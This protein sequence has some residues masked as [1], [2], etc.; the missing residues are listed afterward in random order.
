MSLADELAMAGEDSESGYQDETSEMASSASE[1]DESDLESRNET[2]LSA[3]KPGAHG[4]YS[5]TDESAG[6]ESPD[7]SEPDDD[8]GPGDKTISAPD[9]GGHSPDSMNKL[10]H[11]KLRLSKKH[12]QRGG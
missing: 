9:L 12:L 10:N 7:D 4:G 11:S 3:E 5:T 2:P 8:D 6:D 1:R